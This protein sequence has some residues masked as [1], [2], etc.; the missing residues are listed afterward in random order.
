MGLTDKLIKIDP[1]RFVSGKDHCVISRQFLDGVYRYASLSVQGV[2]IKN[3]TF[4]EH[5]HKLYKYIRRT[6]RV[7]NGS[8][9]MAQGH[10]YR[11]GDSVQL[12][13]VQGRKK[14]PCHSHSIYIS[15]ILGDLLPSAVFYNKAHIK[16]RIVGY[17]YRPFA[18]FH[19]F[20]QDRLDIGRVHNHRI[21][22]AG[23]LLNPVGNR[24]F[25]IYKCGK[26][27]RYHAVFHK[28]R[29]NLDDLAA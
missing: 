20:R 11:L 16:I 27:I 13:T 5:S 10:S 15:K 17:H 2:Q 6:G 9:M 26:T 29:A 18:E 7:V 19:K 3:I 12:K 4:L 8:V 25:R 22:D 23:K 28:N 24:Y 1:P 14:E 21:V